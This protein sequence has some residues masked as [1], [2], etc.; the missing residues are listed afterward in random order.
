[1][2]GT[3]GWHHHDSWLS[4]QPETLPSAGST[5]PEAWGDDANI[6]FSV[7]FLSCCVPLRLFLFWR[8]A[9]A[10]LSTSGQPGVS[11][12]SRAMRRVGR[13]R[14]CCE[15]ERPAVDGQSVTVSSPRWNLACS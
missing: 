4:R 14:G 8:A 6:A 15:V 3:V 2:G 12:H 1:M 9:A 11:Y 13:T 7:A 10:L 5:I